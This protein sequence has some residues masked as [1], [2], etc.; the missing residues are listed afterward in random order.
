MK[1]RYFAALMI[2]GWL[3]IVFVGFVLYSLLRPLWF[4]MT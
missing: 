4:P 2:G 3:V 1:F